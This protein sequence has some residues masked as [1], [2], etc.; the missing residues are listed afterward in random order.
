MIEGKPQTV[1]EMVALLQKMDQ[2][3]PIQVGRHLGWSDK[4]EMPEDTEYRDIELVWEDVDDPE[5][6]LCQIWLELD[7]QNDSSQQEQTEED[8]KFEFK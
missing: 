3:L 1:G 4:H 5:D 2:D 7:V 8:R 6:K